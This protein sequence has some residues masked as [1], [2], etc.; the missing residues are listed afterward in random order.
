VGH[1]YYL[2][3]AMVLCEQRWLGK[4]R[5]EALRAVDVFE[6]FG[7]VK[8]IEDCRKLLRDIQQES[9]SSAVSSWSNFDCEL[10][11]MALFFLR[12]L[13]STSRSKLKEPTHGIDD[14]I[15]FLTQV[16]KTSSLRRT[17]LCA[18]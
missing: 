16:T 1:A 4:A 3:C 10:L 7:A 9:D 17:L 15:E 13:T 14:C 12:A 6:K 2:G 18:L 11:G 5:S 8:G